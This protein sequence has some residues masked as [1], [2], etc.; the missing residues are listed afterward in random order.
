VTRPPWRR[1]ITVACVIAAVLLLPSAVVALLAGVRAGAGM[2]AGTALTLG[3]AA[4][5]ADRRGLWA[6]VV[7][8][9]VAATLGPMVAG[10]WLWVALV[11]VLAALAGLAARIAAT[12]P[13]SYAALLAVVA[14]PVDRPIDAVAFAAFVALGGCYSVIVSRR[15]TEGAGTTAPG[16]PAVAPAAAVVLAGIF[17]VAT[18]GAAAIA[19]LLDRPQAV[20]LPMTV[21]IVLGPVAA[22]PARRNRHRLTG[23]VVGAVFASA[24]GLLGPPAWVLAALILVALI[25]IFAT[26][27]LDYW[28][29]VTFIT[30]VVLLGAAPANR[31]ADVAVERVQFTLFAAAIVAVGLPLARLALRAAAPVDD[32]TGPRSA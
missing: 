20:W 25:G 28:I 23:T 10:S 3:A 30:V 11:A 8:L 16:P 31:V 15:L 26:M 24:V 2:V 5:A 13:V 18:G 27:D 6:A 29:Q 17:A 12:A 19:L 7:A 14:P 21:L 4:A 9:L 1:R 32:T 22:G